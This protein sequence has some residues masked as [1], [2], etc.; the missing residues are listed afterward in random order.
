[1]HQGEAAAVDLK[2]DRSTTSSVKV[3]RYG[4]TALIMIVAMVICVP[5]C[6][7]RTT[8]QGFAV[9]DDT[10]STLH[11]AVAY[12]RP[13]DN[14][15]TSSGWTIVHG[16]GC[17]PVLEGVTVAGSS[18]YAYSYIPH[19]RWVN[20]SQWG[21]DEFFCLTWDRTFTNAQ[22]KDQRACTKAK[23]QGEQWVG[24]AEVDVGEDN[25]S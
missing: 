18:Y 13:S 4:T 25:G 7:Q 20:R 6:A 21:G 5:A 11:V 19:D 8:L 2:I 15:W 23:S 24:F 14:G 12:R 1:M 17:S 3:D 16:N 10:P 9:C 22:A